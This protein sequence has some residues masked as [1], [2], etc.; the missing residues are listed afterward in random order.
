MFD[1]PKKCLEEGATTWIRSAPGW[2]TMEAMD[3][4]GNKWHWVHHSNLSIAL[5]SFSPN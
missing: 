4:A 3:K 2:S 1:P 5:V